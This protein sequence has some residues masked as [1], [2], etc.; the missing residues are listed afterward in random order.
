MI[1]WRRW[2]LRMVCLFNFLRGLQTLNISGHFHPT[3][4]LDVGLDEN[5]SIWLVIAIYEECWF[6]D[7]ESGIQ[8]FKKFRTLDN[9]A[10]IHPVTMRRHWQQHK[11][12]SYLLSIHCPIPILQMDSNFIILHFLE[13]SSCPVDKSRFFNF[14]YHTCYLNLIICWVSSERPETTSPL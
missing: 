5:R 2:E 1:I 14:F 9:L 4:K 11:P 7:S 3:C 8:W 13:E 12:S 6:Q 10:T